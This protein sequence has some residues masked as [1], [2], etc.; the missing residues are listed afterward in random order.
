M[1]LLFRFASRFVAGETRGEA[2]A[3]AREANGRGMHAILNFLGEHHTEMAEVEA[4]VAEYVHLAEGVASAGLD[5]S[6]SVKPTQVGLGVKEALCRDRFRRIADAAAAH[7]L[8]L[9]ID[10]ES[11]EYTDATLRIY[12]ELRGRMERVG[13]CLQANLHRTAKDL[14]DLAG[15]GGVIRLV[16]GAYREDGHIAYTRRGEVDAS[17][18]RLLDQLFET[19]NA[20]AVATHDPRFV[21]R[22]LR[23][24]ATAPSTFEFQMLLGVQDPLKRRLVGEGQRVAEYIP[25]GPEWLPYFFR[26]IQERP[27]N[28]LTGVRSL[29]QRRA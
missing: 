29:F 16:K 12:R 17:F 25:Y 21:E 24:G 1:G 28:L 13:V 14:Q 4:S 10:M 7:D 11:A 9:W 5:A 18:G 6:L 3:R 15:A 27:R 2:V 26:R 23:R 8:F 22:T 20:F 19:Q